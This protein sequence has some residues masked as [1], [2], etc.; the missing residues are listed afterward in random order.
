VKKDILMFKIKKNDK[1]II[2]SGKDKNKFG[3]VVSVFFD[4]NKKKVVV[5]GVN[6]VKKHVKPTK[7]T[8]GGIINKE[9]A[10]DVSN[11]ML[12]CNKCNQPSRIKFDKLS[13]G[14]KVRVCYKCGSI[15]I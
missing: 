13:D 11:V 5:S 15:N 6:I 10:I 2:L 14:K 7:N 4:N 9:L 1:V 8:S 12:V 3:N